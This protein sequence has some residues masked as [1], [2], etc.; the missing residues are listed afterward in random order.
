MAYSKEFILLVATIAGEAEGCSE[1]SWKTIAHVIKNRVG[2]KEWRKRKT[3]TEVIMYTGF[4]AANHRNRPFVNAETNLNAGKPNALQQR[5]INAVK[6]I[7]DGLESDTTGKAVLYY[8]PGAQ[9]AL[10]AQNP[11][12]YQPTPRWNFDILEK[13][14]VTG[15]EADDFAWYRYKGSNQTKTIQVIDKKGEAISDVPY[16]V[17]LKDQPG[18]VLC[19]GK[20]CGEGKTKEIAAQYAG[21]EILVFLQKKMK[22]GQG[23]A[24]TMVN[25]LLALT[26]P[27]SFLISPKIKVQVKLQRPSEPG[28]YQRKIHVVKKGDTLDK[29]A[30]S[31][32][33]DVNTLVRLNSITNRNKIYIGQKIKLPSSAPRP[34]QPAAQSTAPVAKQEPAKQAPAEPIKQTPVEQAKQEEKQETNAKGN[35]VYVA[36]N[37]P[38]D[39]YSGAHWVKCFPDNKSLSLLQA[40]FRA[41]V[42]KFMAALKAGGVSIRVNSL[43]RP[44]Q[45]SYLMYYAQA[46]STGTIIPKKVPSFSKRKA[47]VGRP[48]DENV[49]IDWTHGGDDKAAVAGALALKKAFSLGNNAVGL[50]YNSNHNKGLAIDLTLTPAWGIG[51]TIRDGNGKDV[52]IKSKSDIMAVGKS[53]AVLHW[54]S[55]GKKRRQDNPHWSKT[56]N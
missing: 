7:Y 42:E 27:I 46:I 36:S 40:D 4:D 30:K 56:G 51:K 33:T 34:H 26:N 37:H 49:D 55:A 19:E 54:D 3:I 52:V 45:R 9:K 10:N 20:T 44:P 17:E 21:Q 29:I 35:P 15:T 18:K 14:A 47:E 23:I 22:D 25:G 41:N 16:R 1:A 12:K 24:E 8:S 11:K 32:K 53:Y 5:I 13:V 2:F 43:F 38:N 48:N 31:N 50:P 39:K 6:P 28:E